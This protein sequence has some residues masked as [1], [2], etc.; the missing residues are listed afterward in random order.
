M[1]S[2]KAKAAEKRRQQY[3]TIPSAWRLPSLP[4]SPTLNT[5]EYLDSCPILSV[6]DQ[7]ITAITDGK[8]LQRML[9]TGEVTSEA[10]VTAFCKR[11]AVAQQVIGCCTEMFF[12]SAIE[13]A[14]ELDVKYKETGPVG[15]LH[16]IPVSFKDNFDIEGLDTTIGESEAPIR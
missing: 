14:K 2:W 10:V 13:K 4:T 3:E 1:S 12:E 8:V 11:A 9:Q 6:Q 7:N 15:P 16:G 5:A